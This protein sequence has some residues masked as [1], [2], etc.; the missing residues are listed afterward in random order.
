MSEVQYDIHT[1]AKCQE[2]AND[3]L[4]K[5]LQASLAMNA[6]LRKDNEKLTR[7]ITKL[8]KSLSEG[9]DKI[10]DA[11]DDFSSQ[12]VGMRK[13]LASVSVQDRNF[14]ASTEGSVRPT[15]FE[16]LSKSQVM[17]VLESELIAG[18]PAVSASDIIGYE[19]G[20]PI[21]QDLQH[22]VVS[23]CR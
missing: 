8:E 2:S 23:K 20:A 15:G 6:S 14:E 21:R 22:L 13:S 4:A 18:N 17:S 5:S 7:R 1:G 16:S 3:V 11:L 19:S 12:P 10:M 9:F